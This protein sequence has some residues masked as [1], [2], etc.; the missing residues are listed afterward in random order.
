MSSI[1]ISLWLWHSLREAKSEKE[2]ER[3][4]SDWERSRSAVEFHFFL[5]KK[6]Q[7]ENRKVFF[8]SLDFFL[9]LN[10]FRRGK[11]RARCCRAFFSLS[12]SFRFSLKKTPIPH[13][14]FT[15]TST[16]GAMPPR[17]VTAGKASNASDKPKTD[18]GS[19]V[20]EGC[21]ATQ[22]TDGT[23]LPTTPPPTTTTSTAAATS[24]SSSASAQLVPSRYAIFYSCFGAQ[25]LLSVFSLFQSLRWWRYTRE[26][27]FFS[28]QRFDQSI[29]IF[30][31]S[32]KGH[33]PLAAKFFLFLSFFTSTL[34]SIF[35]FLFLSLIVSLSFSLYKPTAQGKR[36][37]KEHKS[38]VF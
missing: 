20:S 23:T 29:S 19:A 27:D 7:K 5:R 35:F 36:Q 18:R 26:N 32:F 15:T 1:L 2:R 22:G 34:S 3:R 37:E 13:P 17:A 4:T 12:L 28:I 8:F 10:F 30:F 14:T 38:S 24:R 11:K 21:A 9:S 6:R 31:F 16:V 25:R 33:A